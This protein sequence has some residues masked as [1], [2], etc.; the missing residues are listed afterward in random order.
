M[1]RIRYFADLSVKRACGFG[2]LA[3]VTVVVGLSADPAL[4]IRSAAI[5]LTFHVVVLLNMAWRAPRTSYRHREVWLLLDRQHGLPE[6]R[7]HEVISGVMRDTF[8]AYG[9][10][11]AWGAAGC[12][13]LGLVGALVA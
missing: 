13:L 12:W 2:L 9:E 7:A 4:A 6:E 10:R 3:T 5:L 8:L 1:D 11:F